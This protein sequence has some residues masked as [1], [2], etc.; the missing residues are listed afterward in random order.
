IVNSGFHPWEFWKEMWMTIGQGQVWR[1]EIRNKAKDGSIYWVDTTIIPFNNESGRPEKYIAIRFDITKKKIKELELKEALKEVSNYKFA[2]DQSAIVA[3]T[4]LKGDIEYVNDTFC[5]ISKYSRVE[6]VGQ[7][8]RIVSSGYHSSEFWKEMWNTIGNGNVWRNEIRNRAKDGSIYWVDTTI[9][10]FKNDKGR[11]DK[12]IAIRFDI[13]EKKKR[14]EEL[15][16]YRSQLEQANEALSKFSYT[17]AHDMKSPLNIATG[18]I[19]LIEMEMKDC[20]N[21]NFFEYLSRLKNTI[22]R[23]RRLINGIL[24]Y[25]KTGFSG[26]DIE[27]V[28]VNQVV[29]EIFGM[30]NSNNNLEI[31]IAKSFPIVKY[32]KVA[33]EQTFENLLSNAIKYN[34]KDICKVDIGFSEKDDYYVFSV[35]DNGPGVDDIHKERVFDLFENI[36]TRAEDSSGIGLA[37]VKKIVTE[38]KGEI[39]VEDAEGGGAKFIFTILK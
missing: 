6:L 30:H 23:T 9:I 22:D 5:R 1:S 39:R 29:D 38:L 24:D 7:N 13:T 28:D 21:E 4:D 15:A 14:D 35:S 16:N 18:F 33:L 3:I 32:H 8:Q 36:S 12:Y 10:P 34:D 27:E 11:P 26:M 20:D 2:L 19:N 25:S 31:T 37:T 17:A